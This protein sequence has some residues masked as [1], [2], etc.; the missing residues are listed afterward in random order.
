MN[1][2]IIGETCLL[3]KQLRR[4][5][6]I[7]SAHGCFDDAL[8]NLN[9]IESIIDD[10]FEFLM[11]KNYMDYINYCFYP[12]YKIYHQKWL[13]NKYSFYGDGMYSWDILSFFH[14][15]SQED[16]NTLN[17]R[18]LRTKAWFEDNNDTML[19]YYYRRHEKYNIDEHHSKLIN[20]HKKISEKYSKNF[21]IL[22]VNNE[23]GNESVSHSMINTSICSVKI[24]SNN[25]WIGIDDNWDAH[26]DNHLFDVF[27]NEKEIK[28]W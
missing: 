9:A 21:Y 26:L 22:N 18:V 19:Y 24:T 2:I 25:S 27:L 14:L 5:G 1:H 4:C 6:V 28:K 23:L 16:W 10:D 7:N 20:F 12:D 8:V 15:H 3:D 13:N 17:R 11:D